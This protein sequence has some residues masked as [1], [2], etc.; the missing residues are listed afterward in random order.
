MLCRNKPAKFRISDKTPLQYITLWENL[1]INIRKIL[2]IFSEVSAADYFAEPGF[3][4]PDIYFY[5][6]FHLH[7]P[8]V[9]YIL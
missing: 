1:G 6:H 5:L 4:P 3:L 8:G 2:L 7:H 9:C